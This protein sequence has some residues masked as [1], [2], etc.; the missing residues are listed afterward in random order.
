METFILKTRL[1]EAIT[2]SERNP[3]SSEFK[4]SHCSLSQ[5]IN[6]IDSLLRWTVDK[7]QHCFGLEASDDIVQ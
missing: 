1:P 2:V 6:F 7:L 5:F 3:D 4:Y